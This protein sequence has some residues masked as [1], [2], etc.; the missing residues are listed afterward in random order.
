MQEGATFWVLVEAYIRRRGFRI[1]AWR[2]AY[3]VHEAMPSVHLVKM[4][5]ERLTYV[6]LFCAPSRFL[7]SAEIVQATAR[8]GEMLR[9]RFR[10]ASLEAVLLIVGCSPSEP[11]NVLRNVE[12]EAGPVLHVLL[13]KVNSPLDFVIGSFS[14]VGGETVF[15]VGEVHTS[16][17]GEARL[18]FR[19]LENTAEP[20]DQVA[21]RERDFWRS[22]F[23]G[24]FHERLPRYA[25]WWSGSFAP[26]FSGGLLKKEHPFRPFTPK[27]SAM[28]SFERPPMLGTYLLLGIVAGTYLFLSLP[29]LVSC[30]QKFWLLY[31]GLFG[32]FVEGLGAPFVFGRFSS[33]ILAAFALYFLAPA[34]ERVFGTTRLLTLYIGGGLLGV[35]WAEIFS[36]TDVLG[37]VAALYALVGGLVSFLF[38]RRRL[39]GHELLVDLGV[40]L[41]VNLLLLVAFASAHPILLLGGFLGGYLLGVALTPELTA[42]PIRSSFWALVAYGLFLALGMFLA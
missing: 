23:S 24:G 34:V 41:G 14:P 18:V 35:R 26:P 42:F 3:D 38:R 32:H 16:E 25:L 20:G 33:L 40:L 39:L 1:V 13:P 11:L 8:M 6:R 10:A 31:T 29:E 7:P 27:T 9:R 15:F 19:F 22:V 12:K 4:D 36:R 30:V 37:G 5:Q 21:E 28:Q 2:D 17:T